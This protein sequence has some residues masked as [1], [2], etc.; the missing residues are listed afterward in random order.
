MGEKLTDTL[1]RR[2][3]PPEQGNR[4]HYDDAV[5]GFACRVTAAGARSFVVNYRVD[6]RERRITI[7][8]FPD[9]SVA[10]AREQAKS[11]KRHVDLGQDPMAT[12]D[13]ARGAPTVRDLAE[14][15]KAEHGPRKRPRSLA[16]DV[17]LL[18]QHILPRLGHVRVDAVRR[19]DVE[20]MHRAITKDTPTR[21]NRLL[22][23]LSTM[24]SLAVRWELCTINPCKGVEKNREH[25][26]ERYLTGDELAR[27]MTA[28]A[29]HPHQSSANAIRLL[30][31]T[32]SRRGEVLGAQWNEFDLSEGTWTKPHTSTKQ[33]KS[34]RVPLSA[35]ARQ[36]LA[37]MQ[38]QSD[39]PALF[40]GR[41]G[42]DRQQ[43]LKT[44]WAAI[45]R[46]ADIQN[47]RVHDLRHCFASYLA[48]SGL[49]LPVIGAL[50]GHS[51]PTTT[52]RYAHLLDDP[53]RAA[54]EKVGL[55]VSGA[56][57]AKPAAAVVPL[58]GRRQ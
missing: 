18:E 13:Q 38:A 47:V 24:F 35:P 4:L 32:G 36:L 28:L 3:A 55:I 52:Q 56:Q 27:L 30:L 20:A 25:R 11:L 33:G 1:V 43:S 15:Y 41:R 29:E 42:G 53:L 12:R 23:L 39:S 14:R 16:E 40:P 21:A 46:T 22:A 49:S 57:A 9:W 45:C 54:T 34:H 26:R 17:M 8:S 51:S 7:G 5:K 48:S 19:V 10:A 44:F 6:G 37:E 50:L 58:A 31:L 2:L